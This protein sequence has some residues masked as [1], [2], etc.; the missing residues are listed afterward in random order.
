[1]LTFLCIWESGEQYQVL[2]NH[3]DMIPMT[4]HVI[5]LQFHVFLVFFFYIITYLCS[6]IEVIPQ[7]NMGTHN[8]QYHTFQF[9]TQEH[10]TNKTKN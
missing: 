9:L 2:R 4:L 10:T 1:M 5:A 6:M 8:L 7:I 3:L